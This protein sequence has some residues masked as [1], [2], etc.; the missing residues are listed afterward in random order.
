MEASRSDNPNFNPNPT[1][2]RNSL[3]SSVPLWPIID[4]PLGLFE[5]DALSYAHKFFK[6]GFTLLPL[7]GPSIAFTSGLFSDTLTPSLAFAD[8]CSL[9]SIL[10]LL[11]NTWSFFF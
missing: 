11:L 7:L 2:I 8:E 9:F 1:P 10:G 6:F 3:S 5:E 4:G